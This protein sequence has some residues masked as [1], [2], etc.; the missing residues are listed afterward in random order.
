MES[1]TMDKV[2]IEIDKKIIQRTTKCELEFCSL[3]GE[4]GYI[5]KPKSLITFNFLEVNPKFDIIDCGYRLSFGDT[6]F[7]HCPI[8]NELYSKYNI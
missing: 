3:S 5:C 1:L 8:R 2:D 4:R 6:Y 7:C